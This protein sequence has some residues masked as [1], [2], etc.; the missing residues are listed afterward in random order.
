AAGASGNRA[1]WK[2]NDAR[3]YAGSAEVSSGDQHRCAAQFSGTQRCQRFVRLFE[4][5]GLRFRANRNPRRDSEKLFAVAAGEIRDRGY[6]AL[7]PKIAIRKR[8]NVAHVDPAADDYAA[9]LHVSERRGNERTDRR[10]DDRRV[11]FFR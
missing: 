10:E 11:Y 5:E 6:R 8:R 2:T 9:A 3:G 1:R 7:V 4:R